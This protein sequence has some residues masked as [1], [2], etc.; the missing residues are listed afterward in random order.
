M[1]CRELIE[2]LDEYA[3]DALPAPQRSLF[4]EHVAGC[5]DCQNYLESYRRTVRLGRLAFA[6]P[7]EPVPAD[8]PEGLVKAILSARNG[9]CA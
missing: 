5:L 9:D 4:D 3:S 8:V 6:E 2:F 1:T 7:N